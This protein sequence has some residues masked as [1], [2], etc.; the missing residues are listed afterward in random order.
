M[1]RGRVCDGCNTTATTETVTTRSWW[2]LRDY[3]GI[4]GFFC[5]ACTDMVQ[6]DSHGQPENPEAY[7]FFLLKYSK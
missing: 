4:T 5:P 2:T 1:I 3:H 6:H 7:T